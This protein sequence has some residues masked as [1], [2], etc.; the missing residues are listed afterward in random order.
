M[1]GI[2]FVVNEK[3]DKKAVLIDLEEWGDLWEDFFDILI[4]HNR[5]NEV[6]ISWDKLKADLERGLITNKI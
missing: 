2:N 1:K 3:G 5:E 6:E 4:S